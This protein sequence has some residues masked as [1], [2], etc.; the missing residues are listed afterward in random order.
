MCDLDTSVTLSLNVLRR[1]K[2]GDTVLF[3]FGADCFSLFRIIRKTTTRGQKGG[4]AVSLT[5]ACKNDDAIRVVSTQNMPPDVLMIRKVLDG[6]N[7]RT[8]RK[9]GHLSSKVSDKTK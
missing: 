2:V 7:V 1:A 5:N 9:Q 6:Y 3:Q 4:T 8:T